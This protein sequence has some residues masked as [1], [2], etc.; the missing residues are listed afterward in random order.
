MATMIELK[1]ILDDIDKSKIIPLKN[2]KKGYIATILI[3]D[4]VSQYGDNAS[5]WAKQSK[6]ERESKAKRKYFA[7]G[8]AFWSDGK[9]TIVNKYKPQGKVVTNFQN[10]PSQNREPAAFTEENDNLPF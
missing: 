1:L 3:S 4:D 9:V 6:E 8:T 7:N 5:G 10:L 2:G